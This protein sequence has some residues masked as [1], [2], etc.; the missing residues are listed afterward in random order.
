MWAQQVNSDY[1]LRILGD[2]ESESDN[3]NSTYSDTALSGLFGQMRQDFNTAYRVAYPILGDEVLKQKLLDYLKKQPADSDQT[4]FNGYLEKFLTEGPDALSESELK[5]VGGLLK[6]LSTP[7]TASTLGLS[8]TEL[9]SLQKT[10]DKINPSQEDLMAFSKQ[11]KADFNDQLNMSPVEMDIR[12]R[13]YLINPDSTE[14]S[15]LVN[16]LTQ[17]GVLKTAMSIEDMSSAL[18][19]YVQTEFDYKADLTGPDGKPKDYWQSVSETLNRKGGDCEDLSIMYASLLMNALKQR[20]FSD[21]QVRSMVTVMAGYVHDSEGNRFGH[22]MVKYQGLEEKAPVYMMDATGTTGASHFDEVN[23]EAVAEFNDTVFVKYQEIDDAFTTAIDV[24]TLQQPG[25]I[26]GMIRDSMAILT[27]GSKSDGSIVKEADALLKTKLGAPVSSG[28]AWYY[29][30]DTGATHVRVEHCDST[31]KVT[32]VTYEKIENNASYQALVSKKPY[33]G[34]CQ[35]GSGDSGASN[36][37]SFDTFGSWNGE[38]RVDFGFFKIA[39]YDKQVS[40]GMPGSVYTATFNGDK[41]NTYIND[42]RDHVNKITLL[43]HLANVYLENINKEAID[44]HL[45]ALTQ[46][47]RQVHEEEQKKI[48]AQREKVTGCIN[49]FQQK[50]ADAVQDASQLAFQFVDSFN[51]SQFQKLDMNIEYWARDVVPGNLMD[52]TAGAVLGFIGNFFIGS[53]A[54]MFDELTGALS[55]LRAKQRREMARLKADV[56]KHNALERQKL[57]TSMLNRLNLWGNSAF[58]YGTQDPYYKE[59]A[60][61]FDR[62]AYAIVSDKHNEYASKGIVKDFVTKAGN[63]VQQKNIGSLDYNDGAS[64]PSES[65]GGRSLKTGKD[66]ESLFMGQPLFNRADGGPYIDF[67]METALTFKEYLMEFQNI[68]RMTI[69]FKNALW[70]KKR[71]AARA[72]G[73]REYSASVQQLQSGAVQAIESEL[74]KQQ[75]VYNDF[76]QNLLNLTDTMNSV[77]GTALEFKRSEGYMIIKNTLMVANFLARIPITIAAKAA[78]V[79]IGSAVLI[80]AV[81]TPAY[82]AL[83]PVQTCY[84]SAYF[85]YL[86]SEASSAGFELIAAGA[87]LAIE[88]EQLREQKNIKLLQHNSNRHSSDAISGLRQRAQQTYTATA[89]KNVFGNLWQKN[90][91]GGLL[92]ADYFSSFANLKAFEAR[93]KYLVMDPNHRDTST[94]WEHGLGERNLKMENQAPA[95]FKMR[96]DGEIATD[97]LKMAMVQEQVASIQNQVLILMMVVKSLVEAIENTISQAFGSGKGGTYTK[98]DTAIKSAVGF[99]SSVQS[100]LNFEIN[101]YKDAMN[102]NLKKLKTVLNLEW[103][104]GTAAIS[105]ALVP[106]AIPY[107]GFPLAMAPEGHSLGKGIHYAGQ[108]VK[109]GLFISKKYSW[110]TYAGMRARDYYDGG[111]QGRLNKSPSDSEYMAVT[112]PAAGD[113]SSQWDQSETQTIQLLIQKGLLS[114]SDSPAY[115]KYKAGQMSSLLF[116]EAREQERINSLFTVDHSSAP[117]MN[118]A[119]MSMTDTNMGINQ[120]LGLDYSA[121]MGVQK[122][123]NAIFIARIMILTTMQALFMAKQGVLQNMFGSNTNSAGTFDTLMSVLDT[124]NAGQL[125]SYQQLITEFSERVKAYNAYQTATVAMSSELVSLTAFMSIIYLFPAVTQDVTPP[126]TQLK[127]L[128]KRALSKSTL[129]RLITVMV[130]SVIALVNFFTVKKPNTDN[131]SDILSYSEDDSGNPVDNE[132]QFGIN[133]NNAVRFTARGQFM[134]NPAMQTAMKT[135]MERKMRQITMLREIGLA[136][137]D[138]SVDAAAAMFD[139]E[140]AKVYNNIKKVLNQVKT[141]ELKVLE[142]MFAS[143]QQYADRMTEVTNKL[144]NAIRDALSIALEYYTSNANANKDNQTNSPQ[145]TSP[146]EAAKASVA[147]AAKKAAK[148]AAANAKEALKGDGVRSKKDSFLTMFAKNQFLK[149]MVSNLISEALTSLALGITRTDYQA[150][151]SKKDVDDKRNEG[152]FYD[153]SQM[154]SGG[155]FGSTGAIEDALQKVQLDKAF[156]DQMKKIVETDVQLYQNLG[157]VWAQKFKDMLNRLADAIA[158]K[159]SDQKQKNEEENVKKEMMSLSD[160]AE[161]PE[162]ESHLKYSANPL[163]FWT[164]KTWAQSTYEKISGGQTHGLRHGLGRVAQG[165]VGFFTAPSLIARFLIRNKAKSIAEGSEA[166]LAANKKIDDH[167]IQAGDSW[168]KRARHMFSSDLYMGK[169]QVLADRA[170]NRR[171]QEAS[172]GKDMS[173]AGVGLDTIFSIRK[174]QKSLFDAIDAL[175]P[176]S[177]EKAALLAQAYALEK[178]ITSAGSIS[179]NAVQAGLGH[180]GPGPEAAYEGNVSGTLHARL[181]EWIHGTPLAARGRNAAR[182]LNE[183]ITSAF[184]DVIDKHGRFTAA[185]YALSDAAKYERLKKDTGLDVIGHPEYLESAFEFLRENDGSEAA[186]QRQLARI[187]GTSQGAA[188]ALKTAALRTVQAGGFT[189]AMQSELDRIKQ[190]RAA[191]LQRLAAANQPD[192]AVAAAA[193]VV[194]PAGKRIR[195]DLDKDGHT[196]ATIIGE[197]DAESLKDK[198]VPI[199]VRDAGGRNHTLYVSPDMYRQHGRSIPNLQAAVDSAFGGAAGAPQI[200]GLALGVVPILAGLDADYAQADTLL[201]REKELVDLH[202][203]AAKEVKPRLE[204]QT[205]AFAAVQKSLQILRVSQS[206]FEA[207]NMMRAEISLDDIDRLDTAA[208]GAG[209]PLSLIQKIHLREKLEFERTQ[210]HH[211]QITINYEFLLNLMG[212]TGMSQRVLQLLKEKKYIDDNGMFIPRAHDAHLDPEAL[213]A[214]LNALGPEIAP[215]IP[216]IVKRMQSMEGSHE[217]SLQTIAKRHAKEKSHGAQMG[218]ADFDSVRVAQVGNAASRVAS[219]TVYQTLLPVVG[220]VQA[221][222]AANDVTAKARAAVHGLASDAD[223]AATAVGNIVKTA[224]RAAAPGIDLDRTYQHARH[225]FLNDPRLVAGLDRF[226]T[227]AFDAHGHLINTPSAEVLHLVTRTPQQRMQQRVEALKTQ[228]NTALTPETE[229]E[230]ASLQAAGADVSAFREILGHSQEELYATEEL[231]ALT[232]LQQKLSSF[233]LSSTE[234]SGFLFFSE[235]TWSRFLSKHMLEYFSGTSAETRIARQ[236]AALGLDRRAMAFGFKGILEEQGLANTQ[237]SELEKLTAAWDRVNKGSSDPFLNMDVAVSNPKYGSSETPL[238]QAARQAGTMAFLAVKKQLWRTD[239]YGNVASQLLDLAQHKGLAGLKAAQDVLQRLAENQPEMFQHLLTAM[240]SEAENSTRPELKKAFSTLMGKMSNAL[241]HSS[242]AKKIYSGVLRFVPWLIHTATLQDSMPTSKKGLKATFTSLL[243]AS[244]GR[245]MAYEAAAGK[246]G[247]GFAWLP[248]DMQARMLKMMDTIDIKTLLNSMKKEDRNTLITS[249]NSRALA[250]TTAVENATLAAATAAAD[251]PPNPAATA[252]AAKAVA[253]AVAHRD[254]LL[255]AQRHL[256]EGAAQL[257]ITVALAGPADTHVSAKTIQET[258]L[259]AAVKRASDVKLAEAMSRRF[260]EEIKTV[261]DLQKK[262][263]GAR[264][265]KEKR[266]VLAYLDQH[267]HDSARIIAQDLQ[268][269]SQNVASVIATLDLLERMED[270][271]DGLNSRALIRQMGAIIATSIRTTSERVAALEELGKQVQERLQTHEAGHMGAMRLYN[272]IAETTAMAAIAHRALG[273]V[274]LPDYATDRDAQ[275]V[276]VRLQVGGGLR[277]LLTHFDDLADGAHLPEVAKL[278]AQGMALKMA[279]ADAVL[280]LIAEKFK[281][282]ETALKEFFV[283]LINDIKAIENEAK[284]TINLG[285]RVKELQLDEAKQTAIQKAIDYAI[286]VIALR[287]TD[288]QIKKPAGAVGAAAHAPEEDRAMIQRIETS[289]AAAARFLNRVITDPKS[290]TALATDRGILGMGRALPNNPFT[291]TKMIAR[292]PMTELTRAQMSNMREFSTYMRTHAFQ[293]L[294][295]AV[296]ALGLPAPTGADADKQLDS[297]RELAERASVQLADH[298]AAGAAAYPA[299]PLAYAAR[300]DAIKEVLAFCDIFISAHDQVRLTDL[301]EMR[302]TQLGESAAA[303]DTALSSLTSFANSTCAAGGPLDALTAP[304]M[305]AGPLAGLRDHVRALAAA[306]DDA[307]RRTEVV[308]IQDLI[309]GYLAPAPPNAAPVVAAEALA[310][311]TKIQDL[312]TAFISA[313]DRANLT[314]KVADGPAVADKMMMDLLGKVHI[315]AG[316]VIEFAPQGEAGALP[317]PDAGHPG[318]P[319]VPLLPGAPPLPA[320]VAA[321]VLTAATKSWEAAPSQLIAMGFVQQADCKWIATAETP[322]RIMLNAS[323][324]KLAE[325]ILTGFDSQTIDRTAMH[326]KTSDMFRAVF[327]NPDISIRDKMRLMNRIQQ[328]TTSAVLTPD[329]RQTITTWT[330][331]INRLFS[332]NLLGCHDLSGPQQ[333]LETQELLHHTL[334]DSF[335]MGLALDSLKYATTDPAG[336]GAALSYFSHMTQLGAVNGAYLTE[337]NLTSL[338]MNLDGILKQLAPGVEIPADGGKDLQRNAANL[339]TLLTNPGNV[340]DAFQVLDADVQHLVLTAL[341]LQIVMPQLNNLEHLTEGGSVLHYLGALGGPGLPPGV[342]QAMCRETLDR[343]FSN[344]QFLMQFQAQYPKLSFQFMRAAAAHG[345]APIA[346]G[347]PDQ[348]YRHFMGETAPG[349]A[350]A[351]STMAETLQELYGGLA[352]PGHPAAGILA[353]P[354]Q[355]SA[356][357]TFLDGQIKDCQKA[358]NRHVLNIETLQKNI[359]FLQGH[360]PE[361]ESQLEK[362][363]QTLHSLT[364]GAPKFLAQQATVNRLTAELTGFRN[365]L[366]GFLGTPAG[367]G[368]VPA[369][370]PG[371]LET[372]QTALAN[373]QQK[374]VQLQH[375]KTMWHSLDML[376]TQQEALAHQPALAGFDYGANEAAINTCMVPLFTPPVFPAV[377]GA[378]PIAVARGRLAAKELQTQTSLALFRTMSQDMP[379]LLEMLRHHSPEG[380][381]GIPAVA[382]SL[383]A[384]IDRIQD[385]QRA[386]IEAPVAPG[387]SFDSDLLQKLERAKTELQTRK[388]NAFAQMSMQANQI[389]RSAIETP[390][391]NYGPQLDVLT[392]LLKTHREDFIALMGGNDTAFNAL[393][394]TSLPNAVRLSNMVLLMDQVET[395]FN[396]LAPA[397]PPA[398]P[399]VNPRQR[400]FDMIQA[401]KKDLLRGLVYEQVINGSIDVTNNPAG[402]TQAALGFEPQQMGIHLQAMVARYEL[403]AANSIIIDMSREP[404]LQRLVNDFGVVQRALQFF[405]NTLLLKRMGIFGN[406]AAAALDPARV[407]TMTTLLARIDSTQPSAALIQSS[408]QRM[409]ALAEHPAANHDEIGI[410][411]ARLAKT[412]PQSAILE[413]LVNLPH[414]PG[415][416]PDI[417]KRTALLTE[418]ITFQPLF[419]D[420]TLTVLPNPASPVAFFTSGQVALA[421]VLGQL[422]DATARELRA[423][424]G[425]LAHGHLAHAA[426]DAAQGAI[427]AKELA[428]GVP[429]VYA[430]LAAPGATNAETM[431]NVAILSRQPITAFVGSLTALLNALPA[432]RANEFPQLLADIQTQY[433]AAF[434]QLM[435]GHLMQPAGGI[436]GA[437]SNLFT[438]LNQPGIAIPDS[439]MRTIMAN[440]N[441]KRELMAI[442]VPP[443]APLNSTLLYARVQAAPAMLAALP[444]GDLPE[445]IGQARERGELPLFRDALLTSLG[446]APYL[447]GQI[448]AAGAAGGGPA[449]AAAAAD[450]QAI[451]NLFADEPKTL[452]TIFANQVR[453]IITHPSAAGAQADLQVLFSTTLSQPAF[454]S[455]S[456]QLHELMEGLMTGMMRELTAPA[457]A[458]PGPLAA[459][460][461]VTLNAALTTALVDKPSYEAGQHGKKA[462]NGVQESLQETMIQEPTLRQLNVSVPEITTMLCRQPIPQVPEAPLV[463]GLVPPCIAE[464]GII[465]GGFG[466]A[467]IRNQV[468]DLIQ[469]MGL[470]GAGGPQMTRPQATLIYERLVAIQ[471][472]QTARNLGASALFS[473]T[474]KEVGVMRDVKTVVRHHLLE[475]H[476]AAHP[477]LDAVSFIYSLSSMNATDADLTR[478]IGH[479]V[480]GGITP[481]PFYSYFNDPAQLKLMQDKLLHTAQRNPELFARFCKN[482][483]FSHIVANA[484][485]NAALTPLVA[486]FDQFTRAMAP[487]VPAGMPIP[488]APPGGVAPAGFDGAY[489]GVAD[490][491]DQARALDVNNTF[492]ALYTKNPSVLELA[493]A[494]QRVNTDPQAQALLLQRVAN[495]VHAHMQAPFDLACIQNLM[496]PPCDGLFLTLMNNPPDEAVNAVRDLKTILR[497]AHFSADGGKATFKDHEKFKAYLNQ[498]QMLMRISTPSE[499]K[500][501]ATHMVDLI[502]T[503][504][505]SHLKSIMAWI[506]VTSLDS[507]IKKNL[508]LSLA[509]DPTLVVPVFEQLDSFV[510]EGDLSPEDSLLPEEIR[511]PKATLSLRD[512]VDMLDTVTKTHAE[513]FREA[514]SW[515]GLTTTRPVSFLH[516]LID[517]AVGE[518]PNLFDLL[519][520]KASEGNDVLNKHLTVHMLAHPKSLARLSENMASAILIGNTTGIDRALKQIESYRKEGVELKRSLF[521][522]LHNNTWLKLPDDDEIATRTGIN[523]ADIDVLKT[524][525]SPAFVDANDRLLPNANLADILNPDVFNPKKGGVDILTPDSRQKLQTLFTNMRG[526]RQLVLSRM[527]QTTPEM[528]SSD[529]KYTISSEAATKVSSARFNVTGE[530][531]MGFIGHKGQLEGDL[532]ALLRDILSVSQTQN[533]PKIAEDWLLSL[534]SVFKSQPQV[535]AETLLNRDLPDAQFDHALQILLHPQPPTKF[536]AEPRRVA[537][538]KQMLPQAVILIKNLD[539]EILASQA[540]ID[541]LAAR[542]AGLAAGAPERVK[543][544]S[545]IAQLTLAMTRLQTVLQQTSFVQPNL[546]LSTLSREEKT[547]VSATNI[548]NFESVE[549]WKQFLMEGIMAPGPR[550]GEPAMPRILEVALTQN[551][552][553]SL[554]DLLIALRSSPKQI[555]GQPIAQGFIRA[556]KEEAEKQNPPLSIAGLLVK[557]GANAATAKTQT[558]QLARVCGD[559]RMKS[560]IS[561]Q[562]Q[563]FGTKHAAALADVQALG[564]IAAA[565]AGPAIPLTP[566]LGEFAAALPDDAAI[567]DWVDHIDPPIPAG[568]LADV[569]AQVK[570][571]RDLYLLQKSSGTAWVATLNQLIAN[572]NF[573]GLMNIAAPGA[574]AVNPVTFGGNSFAAVVAAAVKGH[575]GVD[576]P[577]IPN[578]AAAIAAVQGAFVAYAGAHALAPLLAELEVH[579]AALLPPPPPGA[580]PPALFV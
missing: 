478:Y 195:I 579:T 352:I 52:G 42:T 306:P 398:P 402:L 522:Q 341:R 396:R 506:Q 554:A 325:G 34:Y 567:D 368:G 138:A 218:L 536:E 337:E 495:Q 400:D 413:A 71:E 569:K 186:V 507:G 256:R 225:A 278:I 175:P 41:F 499:Q 505:K 35:M 386:L 401:A 531:L 345:A 483:A 92:I 127:D 328:L 188:D 518:N 205:K 126:R 565:P 334:S 252:A 548:F 182:T 29:Q 51:E 147:D 163:K 109:E 74:S 206:R 117:D 358:F 169:A 259:L 246:A 237:I 520:T 279:D 3:E 360:I 157:G 217:A 300:T 405:T 447:A 231:K 222:K 310:S 317:L 152:A 234:R 181:Q 420:A 575:T 377:A 476:T 349:L 335:H 5:S 487:A 366:E 429:P 27:G 154:D 346:A 359:S 514:T 183:G 69:Q 452:V 197:E 449:A 383:D 301:E 72:I 258:S 210:A 354:A 269:T 525:L 226:S 148:G 435:S 129:K 408:M 455:Q 161:N 298:L 329:E 463:L 286:G 262:L 168:E 574:A 124:Y 508:F 409:T 171:L 294:T 419:T 391:R 60:L 141:T 404:S 423:F 433:P 327:S 18:L 39:A 379:T 430:G 369:A 209:A 332:G 255:A 2:S 191:L 344:P 318:P 392:D 313:H 220:A 227:R 219:D 133:S 460:D 440:P 320:A 373:S 367:P 43:Y 64:V 551:N 253:S 417:A 176:D 571:A 268:G 550:V 529:V 267:Q 112:N 477:T 375:A 55:Y 84:F 95:F 428:L 467:G 131:K 395:S 577:T 193:G 110:G 194:T 123:L 96:D 122:D 11:L 307:G 339:V 527:A 547:Y 180:V 240:L 412:V 100:D 372:E 251:V 480:P 229:Q 422:P 539:D 549:R 172:S 202:A 198:S 314:Q 523:E 484:R 30:V 192:A 146:A 271:A 564:R 280:K 437:H 235:R 485:G 385:M 526:A 185:Y 490:A 364:P 114:E 465:N 118:N 309:S 121:I 448:Q 324:T 50:E 576:M 14:V 291:A 289:P 544:A 113:V 93:D 91:T 232:E 99:E 323:D 403:G 494:I 528:L 273:A 128:G 496:Q 62:D 489:E 165:V 456:R 512:F 537:L 68:V 532:G 90:D 321:G 542:P 265:E 142:Q 101:Q 535:V 427:Q 389:M 292:V 116:M 503:H 196:V 94:P 521:T 462:M 471:A 44:I 238:A 524:E 562:T 387:K 322:M 343:A 461:M 546:A 558:E 59:T 179:T 281:T 416:L 305:P 22:T 12:Q 493:K 502:K 370:V 119:V 97:G 486:A 513:M 570:L 295:A 139:N 145:A 86:F 488:A 319:A 130:N 58:L 78:G 88:N 243:G 33:L 277:H 410:E 98:F 516:R 228:R 244:Q 511:P 559:A 439:L 394:N 66:R 260:D 519:Q 213:K 457:P 315:H 418:C 293:N 245:A 239:D 426:F 28:D 166:I 382:P 211:N 215:F 159:I 568:H 468:I 241:E 106:L 87:K 37:G 160:G 534:N 284:I 70:E 347:G 19:S 190:E 1:N 10:V 371:Q 56:T 170:R 479:A 111:G 83:L 115:K 250:A 415:G 481:G 351:G 393:T 153:N 102:T 374:L 144:T 545:L 445:F 272:A 407:S 312:C 406:P 45:D 304:V 73:G 36:W 459:A 530:S 384:E 326:Q 425:G 414:A 105:I 247:E 158:A 454:V 264:T 57:T 330:H 162:L 108:L 350:R 482:T 365:Q 451:L 353:A 274:A 224:V 65:D 201:K 296:G 342:D 156:F 411:F 134:V 555:A 63:E 553:P 299:G 560:D 333:D 104:M 137:A 149:S 46:E 187:M 207:Q 538:V 311:L 348:V 261:Q 67:N 357:L 242:T 17:D 464:T 26:L 164:K 308:H 543:H 442:N 285:E 20:G 53:M 557:H 263:E 6:S 61:Y 7:E 32:S 276:Q 441:F 212:K 473:G 556:L 4:K 540:K 469:N 230:L 509:S 16:K 561:R 15:F 331:Q 552:I 80:T 453:T 48:N 288:P 381:A 143:L 132:T 270:P 223:A 25:T 491:K 466:A 297:V 356:E 173:R 338:R 470:A 79:G 380:R 23:F 184:S 563:D 107:L 436:A 150:F 136:L 283:G 458:V 254:L 13:T 421:T 174:A 81:T 287:T 103:E 89:S 302:R 444:A 290:A 475:Q 515:G 282:N 140:A 8:Q 443:A 76:H 472:D 248:A 474:E 316:G 517:N 216:D 361:V 199:Q 47:Q 500:A 363:I 85:S 390:P 446:T 49:K 155:D 566:A 203:R 578:T 510:K 580:A 378:D 498:T 151:H 120:Y 167:R 31:G 125:Q 208:H 257:H 9:E 355:L 82:P 178:T 533:Q 504:A 438:A 541:Q 204:A 21:T 40:A 38:S 399:G 24:G 221:A 573:N 340:N 362:E 214:D 431:L 233:D 397:P 236:A 54:E 492:I 249:F 434:E 189:P 303:V 572:P 336:P 424:I 497:T 275:A 432:A 450:V 376:H 388:Q 77:Y 266:A 75:Q 200:Q 135:Q 177:P 501:I